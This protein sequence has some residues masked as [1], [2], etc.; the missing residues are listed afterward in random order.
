MQR[1]V[2]KAARVSQRIDQ[3][4]DADLRLAA[5]KLSVRRAEIVRSALVQYLEILK[6]QSLKP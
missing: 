3:Q 2:T 4:L 1:R 6:Q 5:K